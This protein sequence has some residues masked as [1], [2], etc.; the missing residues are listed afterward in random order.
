MQDGTD[1]ADVLQMLAAVARVALNAAVRAGLIGANPGRWVELRG[2][3]AA[4]TGLGP[5]LVRRWERRGGS[6]WRQRGLRRRPTGDQGSAAGPS[7]PAADPGSVACASSVAE[8]NACDVVLGNGRSAV[9]V[10]Q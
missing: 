7:G 3:L 9:R 2:G 8:L 1:R 10:G 5:A 6:R 4:A